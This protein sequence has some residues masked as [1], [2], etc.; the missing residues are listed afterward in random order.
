MQSGFF[1]LKDASKVFVLLGG[2]LGGS[3]FLSQLVSK[4]AFN[5]NWGNYKPT[6]R[7]EERI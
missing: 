7:N 2:L 3:C 5:P 1:F 6:D 4:L